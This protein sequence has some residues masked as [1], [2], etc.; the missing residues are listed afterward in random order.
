VT[1]RL[2]LKVCLDVL[3]P[4]YLLSTRNLWSYRSPVIPSIFHGQRAAPDLNE[5]ILN[6]ILEP[7]YF[8]PYTHTPD[9]ASLCKYARVSRVWRLPVQRMLFQQITI[10][11]FRHYEAIAAACNPR[12][13][14]GRFLADC[15]RILDYQ[16][17]QT[18]N[19]V[20]CPE[21]LLEL[22]FPHALR[23]FP[24]LYEL[25]VNCAGTK[26]FNDETMK[27]L[28]KTPP[29]QALR[30]SSGNE[31]TNSVVPFQLL[32]IGNWPLEHLAMIGIFD[33][34]AITKYPPA[35]RNL[36]ELRLPS[37]PKNGRYS[38]LK[39]VKAIMAAHYGSKPVLEMLHTRDLEII[40]PEVAPYLR[41]LLIADC[42]PSLFS[43]LP[44]L[45][46]LRELIVTLTASIFTARHFTA[47]SPFIQHVGLTAVYAPPSQ[48]F[49]VDLLHDHPGLRVISLYF[50]S[51]NLEWRA[52]AMQKVQ[53]DI[54]SL[55]KQFIE[56][57]FRLFDGP[58][59]SFAAQVRLTIFP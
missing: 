50:T 52:R 18:E 4:Y 22:R 34:E 7:L 58:A 51:D 55:Q 47:I 8:K 27:E 35:R 1:V 36:Y 31:N 56:V 3:R 53:P 15:V 33:M 26:R 40:T 14:Q 45:P 24:F 30:I 48:Q 13:T 25:R 9:Y 43:A 32:Q 57:E 5:D 20:F 12:T 59:A 10:K 54:K 49:F 16:L 6:M 42:H 23:L 39:F 38:T 17:K 44:K 19:G 46:M 11:T 28:R 21:T 37:H 29:I 2:A 41:S